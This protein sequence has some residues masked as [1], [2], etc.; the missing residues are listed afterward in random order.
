MRHNRNKLS[1]RNGEF[2]VCQRKSYGGE[3]LVFNSNDPSAI[4]EGSSKKN[5]L[6]DRIKIK[7]TDCAKGRKV[8]LSLKDVR[9]R[10]RHYKSVPQKMN[11]Q[12]GPAPITHINAA[13]K[14]ANRMLH[15][16]S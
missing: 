6:E 13:L 10:A 7:F 2:G 1:Q 9:I 8:W 5:S 11:D 15:C 4:D 16:P 14:A 3:Y 12:R